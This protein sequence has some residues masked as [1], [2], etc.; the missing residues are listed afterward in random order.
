M[1]M[2]LIDKSGAAIDRQGSGAAKKSS[3]IKTN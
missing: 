1:H 3:M 2:I